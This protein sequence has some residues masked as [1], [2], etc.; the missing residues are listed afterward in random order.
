MKDLFIDSYLLTFL[1]TKE[2]SKS[3]LSNSET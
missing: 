2:R 3:Q 1:L